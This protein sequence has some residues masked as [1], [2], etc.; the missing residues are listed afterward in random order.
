MTDLWSIL[1]RADDFYDSGLFALLDDERL[2]IRIS[3]STLK[4]IVQELYYPLSP[5][6]FSVVR[7]EV[8]GE[9]YEQFLGE[10]I[11][12]DDGAV[13]IVMRPEVRESGGV[14]PTPTFI[15]DWIVERTVGPAISGESP[16]S[17]AWFHRRGYLLRI[18]Y[19]LTLCIRIHT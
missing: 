9:I 17:A 10:E 19:F 7:T 5:Y 2:G 12:V 6:T 3:D 13:D 16:E 11:T 1:R 14:V 8:L 4:N 15:A 18:G